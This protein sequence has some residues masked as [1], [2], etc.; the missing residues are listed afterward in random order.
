[1]SPPKP[2]HADAQGDIHTLLVTTAKPRG[3][4]KVR[5]E[6][7]VETSGGVKVP[8]VVWIS[9]ERR[10]AIPDGAEASPVAPEICVE[11]LSDSNTEA[12][13]TEKRRLYFEAGAEEVWIVSQGGAARFYDTDGRLDA[14][15]RAPDF[16]QQLPS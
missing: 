11:V 7:A 1:M 3:E 15:K 14:S 5:P 2:Q 4:G 8:D 6:Y 16:P 10:A 12:E 13:M 9:A